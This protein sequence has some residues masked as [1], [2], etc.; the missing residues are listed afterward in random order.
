ML[1]SKII[2]IIPARGGS[3]RIPGKNIKI[4][5]GKPLIAWTIEP[6][7]K[8]RYLDKVIVST[9]NKKIAETSKRY[10][11]EVVDRPREFATDKASSASAVIHLIKYLKENQNYKPDII[12]LLQPTS[13]LRTVD[14]IDKSIEMFLNNK[15]KAV[16]SFREEK[17]FW[18]GVE[19]KE[20]YAR[21][22]FGS[23]K[24]RSSKIYLP[25]GATYVI[26]LNNFLKYK[27]FY[28]QEDILPY[29]MPGHKSIDVDIMEEFNLAELILK[30]ISKFNDKQ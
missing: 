30:N 5:A 26:A 24:R 23:K 2:A 19:I 6:A 12:V 4:M 14:D 13:P 9:D 27:S 22:I 7:L 16:I 10:G 25:N 3:K 15:C 18:Y 11:A 1:K 21:E 8:S 17:L 29:I 20:K 28:P